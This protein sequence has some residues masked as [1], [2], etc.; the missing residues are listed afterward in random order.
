[1]MKH[2]M[3]DKGQMKKYGSAI[4]M[5]VVLCG[6]A[7]AGRAKITGDQDIAD[8]I[9]LS[10][11][12]GHTPLRADIIDKKLSNFTLDV[13]QFANIGVSENA[14]SYAVYTNRS[15]PATCADF[16]ERSLTYWQPSKYKRSFDLRQNKDVVQA[17]EKFGCIIVRGNQSKGQENAS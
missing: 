17:I 6:L 2:I 8:D 9:S 10:S 14:A 13:Q 11:P 15:M 3:Y 4:V 1:M 7:G 5:L 16:S 12:M